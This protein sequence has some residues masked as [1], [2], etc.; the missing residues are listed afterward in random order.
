MKYEFSDSQLFT[1]FLYLL[2]TQRKVDIFVLYWEEKTKQELKN[3]PHSQ[4]E[5]HFVY[6][7]LVIM[8]KNSYY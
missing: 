4:G 7:Q 6:F 2:M 5:L 3:G 8:N 1:A